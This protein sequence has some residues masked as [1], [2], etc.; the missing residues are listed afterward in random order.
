MAMAE[1]EYGCR[2]LDLVILARCVLGM[3]PKER[4]GFLETSHQSEGGRVGQIKG[5]NDEA[6]VA[7][8]C[9]AEPFMARRTASRRS[10]SNGGSQVLTGDSG[11]WSLAVDCS[12]ANLQAVLGEMKEATAVRVVEAN[13]MY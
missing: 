10:W 4:S 7:S 2:R 5:P 8:G 13:G 11:G 6:I 3:I 9:E 1:V 12:E